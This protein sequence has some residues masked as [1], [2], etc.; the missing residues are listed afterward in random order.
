MNEY[1]VFFF[2][3]PLQNGDIAYVL[4]A[5]GVAP[6]VLLLHPSN[7]QLLSPLMPELPETLKVEYR[8]SVLKQE[9][10]L[11]DQEVTPVNRYVSFKKDT[12]VPVPP[13][14]PDTALSS[15]GRG[16]N[17]SI[18][19]GIGNIKRQRGRPRVIGPVM[20]RT[21]RWRRRKEA[22]KGQE[23]LI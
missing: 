13:F 4:R 2:E 21:T 7:M 17:V 18:I 22:L 19:D 8:D 6:A 10:W 20:S 14:Y 5:F 1:K 9:V 15:S 23:V 16:D 12:E 3:R 11:A